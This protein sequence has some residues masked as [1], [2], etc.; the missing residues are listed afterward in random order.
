MNEEDIFRS[1]HRYE[2]EIKKLRGKIGKKV[3]KHKIGGKVCICDVRM[4][5]EIK[6]LRG[7]ITQLGRKGKKVKQGKNKHK[8]GGKVCICD[9]K[10]IREG[11]EWK[12][13]R[14]LV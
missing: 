10:I 3:K 11:N 2:E 1:I 7:K 14:L 6:K 4:E 5:E 8:I 12:V 13:K 9:A